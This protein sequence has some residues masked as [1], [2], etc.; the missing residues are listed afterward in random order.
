MSAAMS[1]AK[2]RAAGVKRVVSACLFLFSLNDGI[3]EE[4]GAIG[5]PFAAKTSF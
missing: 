4:G 2:S 3:L 1:V 5:G